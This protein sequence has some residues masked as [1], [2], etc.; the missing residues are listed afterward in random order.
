MLLTD[1][2]S[3]ASLVFEMG[4]NW[5]FR[6]R[7]G[8]FLKKVYTAITE[9]NGVGNS[10]KEANMEKLIPRLFPPPEGSYF[11]FGP[12]GTGK[13][14]WL[15]THY[16]DSLVLDL[17]EPD[18]M[19]SFSAKPER[20]RDLV[21]S[22]GLKK[23]I[24]IDEIQ[25]VPELLSAIHAL[26]EKKLNIQF[27]LT[28]SS[29]RKLKRSGTDLLAGRLIK[30]EFHP[31]IAAEIG[32][33]FTLENALTNGMVP[34]VIMSGDPREVLK[35]YAALYVRE[36]VQ[37]EGLVRNIGNFSR[38][39]EVVS[40][41]H[42][43]LLNVSNTARECEV[44]R[45]VVTNYLSILEDLLLSFH[46]DVFS[47]RAKRILISHPKFYFFDAGV[48][49]SLRPRGIL[50]NSGDIT[51]AALEGLVAQHLRAWC[52][53]EGDRNRLY[54]WRTKSGIEVDFILYG[55]TRFWAIEVKNKKLVNSSD[56]KSLKIFREDY[57]ECR[58]ILLYNG[59][60]RL[61]VDG[62]ECIPCGEFLINLKPEAGE[63]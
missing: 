17:L 2:R 38:F 55:E 25:R 37:M 41:S 15:R 34:L 24:I 9:K 33:R 3:P 21:Y 46:L 19:R 43:S 8:F 14:T 58:L 39:L 27:I 7:P 22:M 36:E 44:E 28:G 26:I 48:Y 49:S 30:K 13:S 23:T 54:F 32:A 63:V 51:G 12:R 53:Y 45:K 4:G 10:K 59:T 52:S 60:E 42:G 20:I 11:L 47:R 50:D 35:S 31:F 56:L 29:S 18:I 61:S 1:L 6:K 16:G 57:P 40:F 5:P 62:I